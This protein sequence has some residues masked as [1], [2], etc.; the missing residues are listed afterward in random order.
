M[1][2]GLAVKGIFGEK[3]QTRMAKHLHKQMGQERVAER[4]QDVIATFWDDTA[5]AWKRAAD[6]AEQA[7]EAE[8]ERMGRL[9]AEEDPDAVRAMLAEAR[10]LRDF[11]GGIPWGVSLPPAEP[12]ESGEGVVPWIIREA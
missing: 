6:A 9:L 12:A 3:W 2:V 4:Y 10:A 5:A 8:L 11:L 1:G 7:F